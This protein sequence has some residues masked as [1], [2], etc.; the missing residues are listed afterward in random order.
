MISLKLFGGLS[1]ETPTG[2]L[3]GR[4]AQRRRLAMLALL[5]TSRG[6]GREKVIACL[7][8]EVDSERG[9]RLLS[10]SVYRINKALGGDTIVTAGDELRLDTDRLP[11]DVAAF[12]AALADG[13]YHD[14][15]SHYSGPFLDGFFLDGAPEFEQWSFRERERLTRLQ[16]GVLEALAAEYEERGDA[17]GAVT[18]WYR[19]AGHDPFSPRVAVRLMAALD[20]AGERGAALRHA[21]VF[22]DVYRQEFD[23]D[24]DP[25]VAEFADGLR[26]ASPAAPSPAAPSPAAPV[27]PPAVTAADTASSAVSR[28]HRPA[29]PSPAGP[30]TSPVV[31]SALAAALV[32]TIAGAAAGWIRHVNGNGPSGAD[33]SA[34]A[35]LPFA[36]HSPAGDHEYLAAGMME[37]VVSA[38]AR[39][40]G[41]RVV[42]PTAAPAGETDIQRMGRTL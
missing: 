35:V 36:D 21:R 41:L 31:R 26:R 29:A 14:A 12:E 2:P 8:P 40:E 18:W 5:A 23:A 30:A 32:L 39:V 17:A 28:S 11:S 33:V 27:G 37:E 3:T 24:A 42:A 13:R 15:A 4:A 22:A 38:L 25:E 1:V 34:V 16:A 10:D 9:R 6:L 20:R 19:A 7:W